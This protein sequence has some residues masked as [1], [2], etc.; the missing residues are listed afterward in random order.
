MANI[1]AI[2]QFAGRSKFLQ[3]K[4]GN[5]IEFLDSVPWN[6]LCITAITGHFFMKNSSFLLEHELHS[7]NANFCLPGVLARAF[8]K[9]RN[10]YINPLEF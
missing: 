10:H 6:N 8:Q 3:F 7:P 9:L 4:I 5:Q 1:C 2:C